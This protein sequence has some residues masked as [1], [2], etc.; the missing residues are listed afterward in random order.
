[1]SVCDLT[2]PRHEELKNTHTRFDFRGMVGVVFVEAIRC[3]N[4]LK[5]TRKSSSARKTGTLPKAVQKH[6][7][8]KLHTKT[9]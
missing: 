7:F 3:Y 8:C 4:N 1:M 5:Q 6:I 2:V 9:A